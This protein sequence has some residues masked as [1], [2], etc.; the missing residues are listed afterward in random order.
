[1]NS[2]LALSDYNEFSNEF[3]VISSVDKTIGAN[4][5]AVWRDVLSLGDET[6]SKVKGFL[7]R[8]SNVYALVSDRY[9][10]N[11]NVID[12]VKERLVFTP[13]VSLSPLNYTLVF[14][15]GSLPRSSEEVL[16]E[17]RS[18]RGTTSI[19]RHSNEDR[20]ISSVGATSVLSEEYFILHADG[21]SFEVF[22]E[23]T[24]YLLGRDPKSDFVVTDTGVSANHCK[25]RNINNILQV[26][27]LGSTNGT[28]VNGKRIKTRSWI[29]L[30]EKDTLKIGRVIF[31]IYSEG[32]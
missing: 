10:D 31:K 32:N 1:M 2:I 4:I 14:G 15:T 5:G 28:K 25:F 11:F 23:G 26:M 13:K 3:S 6:S 24:E 27:D 9:E 20:G 7:S 18:V 12:W 16:S 21:I 19:Y 30:G 17:I 22:D 8:G 29:V